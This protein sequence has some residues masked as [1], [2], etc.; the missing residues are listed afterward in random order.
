[1]NNHIHEEIQRS[2]ELRC[3]EKN[4]QWGARYTPRDDLQFRQLHLLAILIDRLEGIEHALDTLSELQAN[5]EQE[6]DAFMSGP[7]QER[8]GIVWF[9]GRPHLV[10]DLKREAESI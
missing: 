1:M 3:R 5:K 8:T 4:K 2:W 10:E 9:D 6:D 7:D